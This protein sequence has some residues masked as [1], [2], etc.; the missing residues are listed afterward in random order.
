M[1]MIIELKNTYFYWIKPSIF[2]NNDIINNK[3]KINA[4][5]KIKGSMFQTKE[6]Q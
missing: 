3:Y 6:K 5:L 4:K 1:M 2:L